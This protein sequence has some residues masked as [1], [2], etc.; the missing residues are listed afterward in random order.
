MITRSNNAANQAFS[1]FSR[2]LCRRA[3]NLAS[4][5][6]KPIRQISLLYRIFAVGV[7]AQKATIVAIGIAELGG[8]G[9]MLR[10]YF[11]KTVPISSMEH[12]LQKDLTVFGV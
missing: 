2:D 11:F 3:E 5:A 7:A 1:I 12:S 4:N 9:P 10:Q 8:D 6:V